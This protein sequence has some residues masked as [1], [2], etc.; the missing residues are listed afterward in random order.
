MLA[1]RAATAQ[2][3]A[4]IYLQDQIVS[5]AL[6]GG[7]R[8]Q[9]EDISRSL[10]VSR[11][12]IREAIRQLDAEGYVTIRPNRGA[13]VTSRTP[14]EILELFEMRAVLEGLAVRLAV[15]NV[16]TLALEDIELDLARLRRVETQSVA[17]VERHDAFHD[18]IC[19]L[20]GRTRLC[21]DIGRLRLAARP[22]LRLYA[23]LHANPEIK[24]YEHERI[25]EALRSGDGNRAERVMR[26]HIMVNA[27]AIASCLPRSQGEPVVK[28]RTRSAATSGSSKSGRANTKTRV[29]ARSGKRR[30]HPR[31][32]RTS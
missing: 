11:M 24:G 12:P 4:Y 15:A 8:L 7:S 6:P 17:W 29:A 19:R 27:E 18:L 14:K 26:E 2:Q 16:T 13:V 30:T 3:E 28:P 10:G 32:R 5:G 21:T 9:I 22:Y 1:N 31:S 23:K 20:S 25:I